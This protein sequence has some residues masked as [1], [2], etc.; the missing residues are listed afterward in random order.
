MGIGLI[1]SYLYFAY[2]SPRALDRNMVN[3]FNKGKIYREDNLPV[4]E[5]LVKRENLENALKKILQFPLQKYFL[6]LGEHGTGKTTLVQ[7]T[8]LNLQ[9]PKGVV[10]FE[11]PS[12]VK[13]FAKNLSKHL[14]CEL[15]PFKLRDVF[16]QWIANSIRKE[17]VDHSEYS[18]W[19][20]LSMQLLNT[21]HHYMKE[22]KRPIVLVLDQ[23]DRIAKRDP[24][25]FE[26]LQD[27]AKDCA[28]RG[29]L[30]IVFIAS[31]GLVPRVMQS[32]SAWSRAKI[33]FEVGDISDDEAMEFLQGSGIDKKNAEDVVK[34]L[35]G[36]RFILLRDFQK[37]SR[38]DA[39]SKI[40]FSE[41]KKEMF[42]QIERSLDTVDLP[43]NH[44]FFIKL[45]ETKH[46]D[47]KQAKTIIPLNMIRK[48]VEANIIKEH[49]DRT[50]SF[51]SRYIETYFKECAHFVKLC[52][53]RKNKPELVLKSEPGE[54]I[55]RTFNLAI[56]VFLTEY[57]K[58]AIFHTPSK[59]LARPR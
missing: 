14:N 44:K 2:E 20:L 7:N 5:K 56:D 27:F 54:M 1:I 10:Y 30:V 9:E 16:V 53:K 39:N 13:E 47:I 51:H 42:T 11:C 32:R 24:M 33:P 50:V 31:D 52:K 4:I 19:N 40:L 59:N 36:G 57:E 37:E 26:I 49:E 38:Y 18:N 12:N 46:M 21:A 55:Y 58:L 45:I 22:Y 48:L 23:V 8:I 15:Y 17:Q 35:T 29:T 43:V 25:F 41:L 28:D 6:I 3:A 34:Y